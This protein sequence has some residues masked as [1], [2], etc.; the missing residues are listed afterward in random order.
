MDLG[1][2]IKILIVDEQKDKAEAFI[3]LLK[4]IPIK[5]AGCRHVQNAAKAGKILA[6]KRY[7]LVFLRISSDVVVSTKELESICRY[8]SN[9][10]VVLLVSWRYSAIALKLLEHGAQDYINDTTMD[11]FLL[12][13]TIRTVIKTRKTE[14]ELKHSN[15]RYE[16]VSKAAN[17]MVWD[18][19]LLN[20]K[21][22]RSKDGW[23][24]V[25]GK[26][27]GGESEMADSW[28]DR[29]HPNDREKS[30]KIIEDILADKS[31]EHF[32]IECRIMRN[33]GE[34]ATVVDRGYVVRNEKGDV[35][36]LIGATQNITEKKVAEEDLRRLSKI[37]RETINAVAITN[38]EGKIQWINESFEKLT[39]LERN[40]IEGKEFAA[41][42]QEAGTE[43]LA[44]RYIRR[45]INTHRAFE[46]DIFIYAKSGKKVWLKLQC[47]PHSGIR[48]KS[49][50][51]IITDISRDK[52][53]E[54]I[55]I[56]SEK[57]FRNII[58]KSSEGMAL[59]N[60]EGE[61]MEMSR[62]GKQ[63]LGYS[64]EQGYEERNQN[65]IYPEDA[66]FVNTIFEEVK[67]LPGHV[68]NAEYRFQKKNGEYIWLESAFHNLL[69]EPEI[70]AVVIH[71][72][73]IS[74]R[75]Y[76]EQ[77]LKNSE[78][79]YRNLFN[80]NPSAI[81]IW[82]PADLSIIEMNEA[83]QKEYGY[84]KRELIKAGMQGLFAKQDHEKLR[85]LSD[86]IMNTNNYKSD[87]TWI[88]LT[89]SG[90]EKLMEITFRGIDYYGKKAGLAIVNNITEKAKLEKKLAEERRER[91][92]EITSAVITAQEQEREELG[93][94]LHDN[95][96]Q[97]LATTKLY[98]EYAISN[99][100]KR[101]ELLNAAKG[102]IESAVGEIR[103]L[104]KSLV[105]PSLGE[106]GL[107]MA[108]NELVKSVEPVSKFRIET[109][110]DI[111]NEK[112]L[113]EK[114]KLTIFRIIQE[115]LNNISKHANAD[116]VWISIKQEKDLLIVL[117]KD[118]GEGFDLQ[119]RSGGVGLKNILSR[120]YLHNG[121]LT[122]NTEKGKG[123][124]LSVSFKL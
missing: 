92:N 113:S 48:D 115:Q 29:V 20:N 26:S 18:W 45:K 7:D 94:E 51:A 37:A 100:H 123:C 11:S 107:E 118:N 9:T 114:L 72:R 119:Q 39:G 88:H 110:W 24:K 109:N 63:I 10:P 97:I 98:V 44:V 60:A 75:K 106:V 33:D 42:F 70:G 15:E 79:N 1:T 17:D 62:A 101:V 112:G 103:A 84:S 91:Q 87:G 49:F 59:L 95:I 36:R 99:D 58:E 117:V 8:N 41:F 74:S 16:L 66:A 56:A 23:D 80:N 81:F 89:K 124:A 14:D 105:P 122:I 65:F 6:E 53:T 31:I 85:K 90:E 102:F 13:K 38:S 19:D 47:Q 121:K 61:V 32:E 69:H 34:Y 54:E 64:T 73:D 40:Q 52:E 55:L 76:F 21:V 5:I 86:G 3:K 108:L 68:K 12:E 46:A 71:F 35:T 67:S 82:D 2:G 28:W 4:L 111:N 120:A 27:E 96:N 83:A 78:E 25:F 77:V 116:M 50:F 30:N 57:R 104:S 43:E 22:F 93:K